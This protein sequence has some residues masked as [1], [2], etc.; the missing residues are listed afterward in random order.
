MNLDGRVGS[1]PPVGESS[2]TV[3]VATRH[4]RACRPA[5]GVLPVAL[6]D[7]P[8]AAL[9]SAPGNRMQ[10]YGSAENAN[11]FVPSARRLRKDAAGAGAG[12]VVDVAW[13]EI[14]LP[15]RRA[16]REGRIATPFL[17]EPVARQLVAE[18]TLARART[19]S[20]LTWLTDASTGSGFLDPHGL[21]VLIEAGWNVRSLRRL[22]AKV[23]LVDGNFGLVGSGNFTAAGLQGGNVE[24]G[25]VCRHPN[26]R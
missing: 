5:G 3:A 1:G 16:R 25:V 24:L 20:L 23:V 11:Q 18:T 10:H 26:A 15:L 19:F 9:R 12:D 2:S 13:E 7:T 17:S 8:S 6:S 14:V 22:H 21:D 4:A